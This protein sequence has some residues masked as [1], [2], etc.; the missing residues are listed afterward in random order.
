MPVADTLVMSTST[1]SWTEPFEAHVAESV[2]V[3]PERVGLPGVRA[4]NV[5][6]F[7]SLSWRVTSS[8]RAV[9]RLDHE[10]WLDVAVEEARGLAVLLGALESDEGLVVAIDGINWRLRRR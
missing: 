4:S 8:R 9:I 2:Y 6:V 3:H 5:I 1:A 7:R 10:P